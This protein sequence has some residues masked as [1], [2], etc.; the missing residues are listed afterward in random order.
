MRKDQKLT[1][2]ND[3][4]QNLLHIFVINQVSQA[5]EWSMIDGLV[6]QLVA[7]GIDVYAKD[8]EERT[9]LHYAC[10]Y[11]N[12]TLVKYFLLKYSKF[13]VNEPDSH[14]ISPFFTFFQS[15][16]PSKFM[17]NEMFLFLLKQGAD[18]KSCYPF[19]ELCVTKAG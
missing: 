4:G 18:L 7:R 3:K 19:K 1:M 11:Q 10:L 13:N 9:V 16:L 8:N 2:K 17:F 5:L 14:G 12:L 6:G 15:L